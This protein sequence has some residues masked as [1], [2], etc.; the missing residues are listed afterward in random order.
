[1]N[2][3]PRV[4]HEIDYQ[5]HGE[6]LQFVEIELDPNETAIA[7][8]GAMLMMDDGIQMQTIFGD[9]SA[10]QPSGFFGK[11]V[12]VR[13]AKDIFDYYRKQGQAYWEARSR[14][15]LIRGLLDLPFF[16]RWVPIL[17]LALPSMKEQVAQAMENG[18]RLKQSD[19]YLDKLSIVAAKYMP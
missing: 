13:F 3:R 15:I 19:W 1:M 10:Q 6:E 4:N 8:S 2:V 18:K 7:E 5:I 9:G 16:L 17:F 12:Y 11:L 14:L